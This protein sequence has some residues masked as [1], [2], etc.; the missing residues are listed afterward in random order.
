MPRGQ[1]KVPHWDLFCEQGDSL[2]EQAHTTQ[3]CT[4]WQLCDLPPW[5]ARGSNGHEDMGTSPA[6]HT[7]ATHPKWPAVCET[8][9][10]A[11]SRFND[12]KIKPTGNPEFHHPVSARVGRL[13]KNPDESLESGKYLILSKGEVR[14]VGAESR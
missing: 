6:V 14:D 7:P 9:G 10:L 4:R 12:R 13:R 3:E 11:I 5:L 1:G 8:V 2:F